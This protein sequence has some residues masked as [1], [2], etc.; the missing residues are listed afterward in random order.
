MSKP[1]KSEFMCLPLNVADLD[2][3]IR[4]YCEGL[5]FTPLHALT[6]GSELA[7]VTG[8]QGEY[9]VLERFIRAGDTVINLLCQVVPAQTETHAAKL[10]GLGLSH[11]N[12]RVDD[13]DN[14]MARV[15]EYGGTI[16]PETLAHF[17]NPDPSIGR[18]DIVIGYDPEGN[19]LEILQM[20]DS[21]RAWVRGERF[22]SAPPITE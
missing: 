11:L 12:I 1:I 18:T 2:R 8:S 20:P 19:R 22:R 13:I 7:A 9:K 15:V 10:G 6:I 21:V 17:D 5:G 3:A 14:A 16:M 4:F